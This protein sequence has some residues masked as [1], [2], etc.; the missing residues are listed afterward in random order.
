LTSITPN[1]QQAIGPCSQE[2]HATII[3]FVEN[4]INPQNPSSIYLQEDGLILW[5]AMARQTETLTPSLSKLLFGLAAL[6]QDASDSL[7]IL[8]KILQSYLLLD[9]PLVLGTIGCLLSKT[10]SQFMSMPM[11]LAPTKAILQSLECIVKCASP[12]V[13]QAWFE[14]SD[15]FFQ[16]MHRSA[17]TDVS[18]KPFFLTNLIHHFLHLILLV[19]IGRVVG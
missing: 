13:W 5:L 15:C 4:S 14:E 11:G 1:D 6:I 10:F 16:L 19:F 18:K 8:L 3:V 2:Y 7:G 12:S 9:C 17:S